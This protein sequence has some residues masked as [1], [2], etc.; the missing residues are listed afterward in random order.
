MAIANTDLVFQRTLPAV[1]ILYSDF[2]A[3]IGITFFSFS[4]YFFLVLSY[5]FNFFFV[6]RVFIF[7]LFCVLKH[8]IIAYVALSNLSLYSKM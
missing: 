5:F 8:T 7:L 3:V 6:R 1:C 4:V 2:A